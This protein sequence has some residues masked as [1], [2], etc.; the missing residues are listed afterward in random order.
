MA[1]DPV[2]HRSEPE[3]DR[4]VHP[5]NPRHWLITSGGVDSAPT[6]NAP[7]HMASDASPALTTPR[8]DDAAT[9]PIARQAPATPATASVH[10]RARTRLHTVNDAARS[11]DKSLVTREGS[12]GWRWHR[13]SLPPRSRRPTAPTGP[14]AA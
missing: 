3:S 4:P 9:T 2:G 13:P 11:G 1:P 5:D 7:E 6:T 10:T 14:A 12:D 8:E